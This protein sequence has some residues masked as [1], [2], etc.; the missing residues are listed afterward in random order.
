MRIAS[1]AKKRRAIASSRNRRLG[2]LAGHHCE[3]GR[4]N[5]ALASLSTLDFPMV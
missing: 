3:G 1:S 4:F 2:K 5:L